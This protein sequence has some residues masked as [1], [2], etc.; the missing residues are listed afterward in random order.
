MTTHINEAA[1]PSA[2]NK[3]SESAKAPT[4]PSGATSGVVT[5]PTAPGLFIRIAAIARIAWSL[6]TWPRDFLR[7]FFGAEDLDGKPFVAY[8]TDVPSCFHCREEHAENEPCPL[9]GV[10]A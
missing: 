4:L 9:W 2:A 7:D 5:P 10:G 6:V 8:V 3:S 1:I